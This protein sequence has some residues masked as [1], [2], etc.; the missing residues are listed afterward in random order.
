MSKT[1][2]AAVV[3]EDDWIALLSAAQQQA[4]RMQQNPDVAYADRGR[5]IAKIADR[6]VRADSVQINDE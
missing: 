2:K 6:L 4:D 5:K 3:S 1:G